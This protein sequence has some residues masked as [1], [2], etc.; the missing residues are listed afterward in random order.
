MPTWVNKY[1]E[2]GHSG[3]LYSL[4]AEA[5]NDGAAKFGLTGTAATSRLN[6]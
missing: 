2:S 6:P 1:K 3:Y 4:S 5:A